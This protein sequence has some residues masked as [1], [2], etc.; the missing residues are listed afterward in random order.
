M[1]FLPFFVA[2]TAASKMA[3]ARHRLDVIQISAREKILVAA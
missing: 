3:R 1:T 2:A